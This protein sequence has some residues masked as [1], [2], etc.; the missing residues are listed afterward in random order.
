MK[1]EDTSELPTAK[2]SGCDT[3]HKLLGLA[4]CMI[5]SQSSRKGWLNKAGRVRW[6][7]PGPALE[8]R[9]WWPEGLVYCLSGT[10]KER[11]SIAEAGA[12]LRVLFAL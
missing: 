7:W 9:H 11:T 2:S 4:A 3:G 6:E 5:Q 8:V 1:Q 10:G 12:L